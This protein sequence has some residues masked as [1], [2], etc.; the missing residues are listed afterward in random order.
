MTPAERARY[1]G[2]YAQGPREMRL[3]LR[4]DALVVAGNTQ[5]SPL[6][7]I[8][9]ETFVSGTTRY[10]FVTNSSGAVTFLHTGGRSW[11]KIK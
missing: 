2:T 7:K 6:E 4:G 9:D 3:E 8:G 11:R 10:V 1:V 5:S